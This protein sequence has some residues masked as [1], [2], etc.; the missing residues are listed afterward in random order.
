M[1]RPA[2]GASRPP[3]S[4][5]RRSTYTSARCPE[6]STKSP[7]ITPL[8]L[9]AARS[10]ARSSLTA[11]PSPPAPLSGHSFAILGDGP[12]APVFQSPSNWSPGAGGGLA[13]QLVHQAKRLGEPP[14]QWGHADLGAERGLD[15]PPQPGVPQR[16]VAA[17]PGPGGGR[18]PAW[19]G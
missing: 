2:S 9:I 16:Q 3:S 5:R 1:T 13:G 8:A 15:V 18:G 7:R 14:G 17:G 12:P 10:S 4:T 6:E 19:P 11:S